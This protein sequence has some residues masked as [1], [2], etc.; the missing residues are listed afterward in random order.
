MLCRTSLAAAILMSATASSIAQAPQSPLPLPFPSFQGTE[1]EQKACQPAVFKFCREALPDTFR[2]L[3][4]LQQNRPRIGKACQQV[5]SS[6][7]V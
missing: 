1:A 3:N 5:L 2:I 6:N 4:C 7:G